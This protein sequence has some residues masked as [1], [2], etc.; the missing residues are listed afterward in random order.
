MYVSQFSSVQ[1]SSVSLSYFHGREAMISDD[2]FLLFS[3]KRGSLESPLTHF[4]PEMKPLPL[5]Y[6]EAIFFPGGIIEATKGGLDG[7]IAKRRSWKV[8]S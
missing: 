1:F 4:A 8:N 7:K 6:S 5:L 3:I 2:V